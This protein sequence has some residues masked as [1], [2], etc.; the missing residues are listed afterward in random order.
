MS[1]VL[2]RPGMHAALRWAL[3]C[4]L[5]L[6]AC[7]QAAPLR[8]LHWWKS[9]SERVAT[10]IIASKVRQAGIDWLDEDAGDGVAAGIILRSRLLAHDL[11]DVALAN[12]LTA[13]EWW[14]LGLLSDLDKVAAAGNWSAR[15]LPSVEKLVKP[16]AHVVAVPLGVHRLNTMFYNRAVFERLQL[17]PPRNWQEFESVALKLKRAGVVPLAQSSQPWQLAILF[18]NI[19]L[20]DG[21]VEVHNHLFVQGSPGRYTDPDV[22][23]ALRRFRSMKKWMRQP[24]AEQNWTDTTR[25]LADGSAAMMIVG[26]WVKAEMNIWGSATDQV[27]GCTSAPGTAGIHLYDLDTLAMLDSGRPVRPAQEKVAALAMTASMQEHYNRVKGSVPVL[28]QV[29]L[30]SMDSCARAS[31]SLL[32]RPG[33]VLVPS[34]SIGMVGEQDLRDVLITELHRF[35]MDDTISVRDTQ[36]RLASVSRAFTKTRLP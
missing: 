19:L 5:C 16:G 18:E 3:A 21:G 2:R 32:A 34:M 6:A 9:N 12:S 35:F 7:A 11:P 26:D 23:A 15:L 22:A 4:T 27:F 14:Q 17:T 25:Q 13:F 28:R 30:A 29:D 24:L 33:A 36:R 1:E 31:W 8:V 20:A 10:D